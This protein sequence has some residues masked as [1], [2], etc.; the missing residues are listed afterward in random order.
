MSHKLNLRSENQGTLLTLAKY[1]FF[2][3]RNKF[4]ST[5][6]VAGYPGK[7]C[8]FFPQKQVAPLVM[9]PNTESVST[10]EKHGFMKAKWE[11]AMLTGKLEVCTWAVI[12]ATILTVSSPLSPEQWS[13]LAVF[14][15]WLLCPYNNTIML[16]F[17]TQCRL[18]GLGEQTSLCPLEKSGNNRNLYLCY[19]FHLWKKQQ[20]FYQHF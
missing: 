11:K 15:S 17:L 3:M 7:V 18:L 20:D 8:P 19:V 12:S 13:V 4:S 2:L 5:I 14:I 16:H 10:F 6:W 9:A 1:F